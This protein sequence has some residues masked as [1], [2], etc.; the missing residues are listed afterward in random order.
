MTT[1][2]D[3]IGDYTPLS[4]KVVREL[5]LIRGALVC[6]IF[7]TSNLQDRVCRMG[8][9]RIADDLGIDPSTASKNIDWLVENGYID[10]IKAHTT[11]EPAH[12][13]C[14]QKFYNLARGID[15]INPPIDLINTPIDNVNTPIDLINQEEESKEEI[16]EVIPGPL[17]SNLMTICCIKE[18]SISKRQA[19]SLK[20]TLRILVNMKIEPELLGRFEDFWKVNWRG[21]NGGPPSLLQVTELWGEFEQWIKHPN[22]SDNE[23]F[24][25]RPDGKKVWRVG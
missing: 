7:Y 13:R 25:F 18:E 12:Y 9:T 2:Q 6:K 14:T 4:N 1:I 17:A 20:E 19:D 15:L 16:K 11:T 24:Y 23:D 22:G 5:K 10:R 8:L 21:K 3:V